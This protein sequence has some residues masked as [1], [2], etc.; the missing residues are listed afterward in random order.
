MGLYNLKLTNDEIL[1][2]RALYE[3]KILDTDP[4]DSYDDI[5]YLAAKIYRTPIAAIS[6]IDKDRH[7]FKARRG[8]K[9]EI[10]L[11]TSFCA[12]VTKSKK[13]IV[14]KDTTVD[15][16][17]KDFAIV[18]FNPQIRFYAGAPLITSDGYYIGALSVMDTVERDFES[19]DLQA[20]ETL[21]RQVMYQL[22]LRKT[23]LNVHD[24]HLKFLHHA[25]L[26]SLG[27]MAASIAHEI[28]N[29]LT[30]INGNV[31]LLRKDLKLEESKSSKAPQYLDSIEK[32]VQRIDKII[33]GL[34][35][36]SQGGEGEPFEETDLRES[37]AMAV[38]MIRTNLKAHDIDIRESYKSQVAKAECRA[39]Q[40]EQIVVN[41]L[42]NTLDAIK[43]QR[44]KWV[45][46]QIQDADDTWKIVI[47]DSGKG[48]PPE[49]QEKIM[50]PFFTTKEAKQGMG[51]GLSISKELAEGLGGSLEL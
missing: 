10:S 43:D 36:L 39:F 51:L 3:Y 41:L 19:A 37:L 24:Q 6:F 23:N 15:K 18:A 45:D 31:G 26:A 16:R 40:V 47:T 50:K 4:E 46:I 1:R 34:K 21:A 17:F 14:V 13:S 28:N 38:S 27:E 29:P 30:I 11:E 12:V 7:W 20:L 8:L 9:T 25:K 33:R 32:T 49:L 42:S 35:T 22:E 44:D 48:I 2:I 5:T